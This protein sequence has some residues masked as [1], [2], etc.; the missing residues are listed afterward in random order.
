MYE[1]RH[2]MPKALEFW[3]TALIPP[4]LGGVLALLP[5]IDRREAS[6]NRGP[7]FRLRSVVVLLGVF[8]VVGWLEWSGMRRDARDPDLH[9]ALAK[10]NARA[11]KADSLALGGVPPQGPLYML[12]H[13]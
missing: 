1:L 9:T 4:A 13:D 12:E 10:W 8:G 7:S 5:W 11:D 3:G 6:D 2:R